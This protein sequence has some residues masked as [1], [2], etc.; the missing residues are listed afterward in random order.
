MA[1]SS[2]PTLNAQIW[3]AASGNFTINEPYI[4]LV[5]V[6]TYPGA[7]SPTLFLPTVQNS[8][9]RE[10]LG[11]GQIIYVDDPNGF[12]TV[13]QP[14]AIEQNPADTNVIINSGGAG[15]PIQIA[16]TTKLLAIQYLGNNEFVV[17]DPVKLNT[18]GP[19]GPQGATG[20]TGATG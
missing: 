19:Q 14:L 16:T 13:S 20:A 17:Y 11:F 3:D 15:S 6:N 4:G 1:Q 7:G 8:V 2:K 18:G 12:I 5:K 10:N 9:E